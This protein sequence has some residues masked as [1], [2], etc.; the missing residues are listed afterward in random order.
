[1]RLRLLGWFASAAV[2][3]L[4]PWAVRNQW[5][6][7]QPILTTTHGGYTLLLGNNPE[8][9]EYLRCGPPGGVW[10][11]G[12]WNVA[13]APAADELQADRQAYAKAW[14]NIRREPG[15]FLYAAGVR[16]GRLWAPTPHRVVADAGGWP[17]AGRYAI[18][19]WYLVELPLAAVGAWAV[20]RRGFGGRTARWLILAA[21]LQAVTWTAM[22]AVYW[23]NMRMR[24]PLMPAIAIAATGGLAW[25]WSLRVGRKS[26]S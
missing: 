15:M 3:V 20:L 26:L 22:H 2:V 24:A 13:Q 6:F 19:L 18:A 21:V 4:A 12:R 17:A 16:V 8:F 1:V 7:G 11:A 14:Q 5:R 25:I 10:D 9:Y 23:S